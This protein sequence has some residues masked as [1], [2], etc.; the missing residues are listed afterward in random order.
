MYGPTGGGKKFATNFH[1][2]FSAEFLT[3]P[4][5]PDFNVLISKH[6]NIIFTRGRSTG[7]KFATEIHAALFQH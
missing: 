3:P 2:M 4:S 7:K 5:P 6:E 1:F